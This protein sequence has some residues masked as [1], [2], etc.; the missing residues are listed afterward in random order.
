MQT[1][2][3]SDKI[4]SRLGVDRFKAQPCLTRGISAKTKWGTFT[5][6]LDCRDGVDSAIMWLTEQIE[7]SDRLIAQRNN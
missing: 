1:A 4:A 3:S 5:V 7:S 2:L 6:L